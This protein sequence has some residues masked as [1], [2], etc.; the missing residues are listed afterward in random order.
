MISS[1][2]IKGQPIGSI[3]YN[4][5]PP[6]RGKS[7]NTAAMRANASRRPETIG[8]RPFPSPLKIARNSRVK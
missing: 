3:T 2:A 5:C 1:A 6:A 8:H 4:P 7:K